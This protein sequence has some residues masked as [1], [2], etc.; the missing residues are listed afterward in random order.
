MPQLGPEGHGTSRIS[1]GWRYA[2]GELASQ[3]CQTTT[4]KHIRATD[5]T[6][7]NRDGRSPKVPAWL[8]KPHISSKTGHQRIQ[9]RIIEASFIQ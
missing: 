2:S 6:I 9:H 5:I 7:S 3:V 4:P 8:S 1:R